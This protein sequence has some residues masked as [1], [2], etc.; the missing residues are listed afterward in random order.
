MEFMAGEWQG[1][2]VPGGVFEAGGVFAGVQDAFDGQSGGGGG[3]VA[4]AAITR[5][6]DT[7]VVVTGDGG[8]LMGLPDLDSLIRTAESA[9]VL[10]FNDAAYGAEVHQYGSQGISE[11]IMHIEQIDFAAVA[12]GMGAQSACI[13][14]PG[15]LDQLEQWIDQGA[16]GTFLADL[17]VSQQVVAPYIQEIINLALKKPA[18]PSK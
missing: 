9:V 11:A 16:T 12:R 1:L 8:G 5:P 18:L 4:G 6:E 10:V 7:I 15:D 2:D 14:T 17:H 3:V 13:K